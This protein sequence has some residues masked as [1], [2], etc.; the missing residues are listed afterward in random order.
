MLPFLSCFGQLFHHS[1]EKPRTLGCLWTHFP[2]PLGHSP[3]ICPT[4]FCPTS[5]LRQLKEA[6]CPDACHGWS[7]FHCKSSNYSWA[8]MLLG[9]I[10]LLFEGKLALF[11]SDGCFESTLCSL[12]SDVLV[13]CLPDSM[14]ASLFLLH[15]SSFHPSNQQQPFNPRWSVQWNTRYEFWLPKFLIF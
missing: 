3:G 10:S 2:P 7:T 5:P 6:L 15:P 11:P 9:H 14:E 13:G 8:S 12:I 4:D 1:D